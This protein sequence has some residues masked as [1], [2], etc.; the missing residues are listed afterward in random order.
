[1]LAHCPS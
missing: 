1:M